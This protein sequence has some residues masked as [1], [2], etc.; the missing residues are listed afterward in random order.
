MPDDELAQLRQEYRNRL[1]D[2]ISLLRK[3][4]E[5]IQIDINNIKENFFR[6]SHA[7]ALSE[8]V[9]KLENWKFMLLGVYVAT[10]TVSLIVAWVIATYL[11]RPTIH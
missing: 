10:Q 8:R 7:E 11:S 9:T 4:V 2:D 3:A 5:T 1:G 6:Q